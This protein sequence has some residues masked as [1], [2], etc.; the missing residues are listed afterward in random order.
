M[1]EEKGR[2]NGRGREREENNVCIRCVS[3]VLRVLCCV[4]AGVLIKGVWGV[5]EAGREGG[6]GEGM[7][8]G[9]KTGREKNGSGEEEREGEQEG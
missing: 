5:A 1:R 3:L 9:G 7:E 4:W 6:R 2:E 8:E